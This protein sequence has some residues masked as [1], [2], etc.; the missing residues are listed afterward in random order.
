MPDLLK[1][2]ELSAR[3]P[4]IPEWTL[5]GNQITRTFKFGSF[6]AAIKFVNQLAGIAEDARHHPDIDIRYNRVVLHLTTHDAGG[7]TDL[8]FQVAHRLDRL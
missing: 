1:P 5:D 3:L 4:T 6:R 7:L 2:E 8:D